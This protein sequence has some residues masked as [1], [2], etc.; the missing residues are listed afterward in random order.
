MDLTPSCA[1]ILQERVNAVEEILNSESDRLMTLRDT[2]KGRP[3][4]KN[5][6]DLARG[7]CRIQYGQVTHFEYRDVLID[8]VDKVH[9]ARIGC[10]TTG[11]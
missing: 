5:L 8:R 2:L 3:L 7:L 11:I 10:I 9:A 6:P 4:L 1:R